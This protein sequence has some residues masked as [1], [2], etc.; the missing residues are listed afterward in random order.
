M[1]RKKKM[2]PLVDGLG[3]R[4]FKRMQQALRQIWSWSHA[5]KLCIVRVTDKNGYARCEKCGAK[6]LPR[7]WPDHIEPCGNLNEAP[8]TPRSVGEYIGRMFVPSKKLQAI[9][10]RCHQDKTNA[11]NRERRERELARALGFDQ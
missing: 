2:S 5:R 9:C 3:P 1:S 4:D 7:V 11:E 6:K 8:L 10:K